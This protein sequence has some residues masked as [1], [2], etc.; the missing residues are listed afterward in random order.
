MQSWSLERKIRVSQTRIIEFAQK[1]NNK[2]YVSFSGGKDS[3]VLLD[4]V[5]RVYPAT[6]R[7][8]SKTPVGVAKAMAE[9]WS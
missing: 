4:M 9:Q 5:R 7:Y 3:T 6:A 8:R 2:I 1:T